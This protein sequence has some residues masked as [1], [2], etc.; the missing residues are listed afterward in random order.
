MVNNET[1]VSLLKIYF[2]LTLHLTQGEM[3]EI[4]ERDELAL[5]TTSQYEKLK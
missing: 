4:S 5:V 2:E 1:G 3:R